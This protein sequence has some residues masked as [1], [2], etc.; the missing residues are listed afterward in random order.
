[1]TCIRLLTCLSM[2]ALG[3]LLAA[4]EPEAQPARKTLKIYLDADR[5]NHFESA[6]SIEM[7]LRTAIDEVDSVLQGYQVEIVP[8][9]HRGNAV[10][11]KR[12]MQTFLEDPDAL[13]LFAGLHSPPLIKHRDFINGEGILTLVPWA[14]GGPITRHDTEDNW[15]FRLSIDDSKAGYRIADFAIE[16]LGCKAPH[17]LL[18]ET[19]WG[20]SNDKTMSTA[21]EKKLGT[22]PLAAWFGWGLDINSA[23]IKLRDIVNGGADCILMV[24]NALEG[25]VFANAMASL[26]AGHRIPLVSHWG[27]TGGKFHETVPH[28][29]RSKLDLY[30]IQT[31]FSFVSSPKTDHSTAVLKRAM[32][33]FPD[34]IGSSRDLP[35]PTGFIHAYDLGLILREALQHVELTGAPAENRAKLRSALQNIGAP[36]HGLVRTY[37]PPFRPYLTAAPDAHEALDLNDFCMGTFGENDEIRLHL[38]EAS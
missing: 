30:F 13:V 20:K 34:E 19:G 37:A 8:L 9:D 21:I 6:R 23:R 4:H 24:A 14:A 15:I 31:C 32:R 12:N 38:D 28:A 18:E 17:L 33:L 29:T 16:E 35:A 1:M 22:K 3:W 10:R 7:G 25:S 36:I 27:I 5:S 11:S 26:D 2:A